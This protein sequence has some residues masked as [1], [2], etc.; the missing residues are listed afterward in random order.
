MDQSLALVN[1]TQAFDYPFTRAKSNDISR[2][3]P[4]MHESF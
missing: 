2:V 4:R 1:G 3:L